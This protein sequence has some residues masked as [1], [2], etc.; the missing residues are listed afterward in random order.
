MLD[1]AQVSERA[2]Y[3]LNNDVILRFVTSNRQLLV[4]ILSRALL[5]NTFA[6]TQVRLLSNLFDTRCL[7]PKCP[8][9]IRSIY[10]LSASYKYWMILLV[11]VTPRIRTHC[12]GRQGHAGVARR[13]QVAGERALE[14]HHCGADPGHPPTLPRNG[15]GLD[16]Q[17][18]HAP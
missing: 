9:C 3:V 6:Q 13:H 4:P 5:S 11:Y 12:I 17:C 15:P 10:R 7:L 8:P 16:D 18:K 14:P 2:I 1:C